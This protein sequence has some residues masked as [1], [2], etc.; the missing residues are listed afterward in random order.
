MQNS[1]FLK[2]NQTVLCE[3]NDSACCITGLFNWVLV[4]SVGK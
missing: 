2:V 4:E 3:R 1:L